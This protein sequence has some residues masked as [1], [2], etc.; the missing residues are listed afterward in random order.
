MKKLGFFLIGLTLTLFSFSNYACAN[1]NETKVPLLEKIYIA[2][3]NF[4]LHNNHM[5]VFQ[6]DEW[7]QVSALYSDDEGLFIQKQPNPDTWYCYV[8]RTTHGCGWRCPNGVPTPSS[9]R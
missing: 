9:C 4:M 8:C 6:N 7:Q 1:V 2:P 3:E 5:L